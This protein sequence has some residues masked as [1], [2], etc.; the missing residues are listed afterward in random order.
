M[1][2]LLS[3]LLLG[4]KNSMCARE[5]LKEKNTGETHKKAVN[6]REWRR[7][8]FIA[9]EMNPEI[10]TGGIVKTIFCLLKFKN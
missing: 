5:L 6:K 3:G 4:K 10:F 9:V 1:D 7:L 8:K 2:Y